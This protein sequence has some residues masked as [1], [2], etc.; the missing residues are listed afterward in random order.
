M[1]LRQKIICDRLKELA[2]QAKNMWLLSLIWILQKIF[3]IFQQM[4]SGQEKCPQTLVFIIISHLRITFS[5]WRIKMI[6]SQNL[7]SSDKPSVKN[8]FWY[9]RQGDISNVLSAPV[10]LE[11]RSAPAPYKKKEWHSHIAPFKKKEWHSLIAISSKEC[12]L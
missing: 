8:Q 2:S 3:W 11:C 6:S 1:S 7:S 12:T 9:L 10:F 4:V 5:F